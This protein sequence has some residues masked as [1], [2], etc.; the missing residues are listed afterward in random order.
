[1]FCTG[2]DVGKEMVTDGRHF[3]AACVN[4]KRTSA[5]SPQK[6]ANNFPQ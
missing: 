3:N 4:S 2:R 6:N 5:R 1:M